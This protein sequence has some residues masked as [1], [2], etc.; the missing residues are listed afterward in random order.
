MDKILLRIFQVFL[1][2]KEVVRTTTTRWPLW[3]WFNYFHRT[4]CWTWNAMFFFGI[5]LPW[6]SPVGLRALFSVEPFMPDLEL[7]QV[8]G[9]L[10]PR[11]SSLTSTLCS[12]L[13]SLWRHISKS[14]TH[15]ETEPDTG[16]I[17]KGFTRHVNRVWNYV[18]KGMF[19]TTAIVVGFPLLCLAISFISVAIALTAC[20]WMPL[21]T[22]VVQVFNAVIYDLDSPDATRNRFMVIFEAFVWNIG[23]LG[24]LQPVAAL[25]VA[26]VICPLISFVILTGN[27]S[28]IIYYQCFM[29]RNAKSIIILALR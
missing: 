16:F 1:V 21:L 22:L 11:K 26:V 4:W 8:N 6:C 17:G 19:G 13:L 27:K 12:R 3:R 7:S 2:E 28:F 25:F 18:V 10:F 9:T 20:V 5:V 15:F 29:H 23:F 24:V 14:R